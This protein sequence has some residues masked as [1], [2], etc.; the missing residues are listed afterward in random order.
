MEAEAFNISKITISSVSLI[1]TKI[2]HLKCHKHSLILLPIVASFG[3]KSLL[4]FDQTFLLI[5]C[6][7]KFFKHEAAH[8]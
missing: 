6:L 2:K 3:H 7:D 5:Q 4:L 1:C 8:L